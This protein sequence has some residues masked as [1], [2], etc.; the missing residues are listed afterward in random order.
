MTV[1]LHGTIQVHV[2]KKRYPTYESFDYVGVFG[3]NGSTKVIDG[4]H[5]EHFVEELN[6][7]QDLKGR[8]VI[9]SS[10]PHDAYKRIIN[11][12]KPVHE[13]E[14]RRIEELYN[15]RLYKN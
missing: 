2:A 3:T 12:P 5:I 6:N 15:D 14:L 7:D 9:F 4:R 1:K 13:G 10:E 11:N 8:M